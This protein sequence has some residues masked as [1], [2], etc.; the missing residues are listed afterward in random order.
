MDSDHKQ[1]ENIEAEPEGHLSFIG[2]I[3]QSLGLR[4]SLRSSD[5]MDWILPNH[6]YYFLLHL[7]TFL[8]ILLLLV[9]KRYS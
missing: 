4:R 2:N 9:K 6:R 7:N 8:L 3:F 1:E 5:G